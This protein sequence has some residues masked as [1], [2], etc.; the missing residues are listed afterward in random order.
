[1]KPSTSWPVGVSGFTDSSACSVSEAAA[2][3][4]A[5]SSED[6][7]SDAL[8]VTPCCPPQAV[9]DRAIAP[10]SRPDNNLFFF[11]NPP[12]VRSFTNRF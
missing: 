5:A 1:M 4:C 10:A 2:C 8:F 11:I 7:A 12:L 3:V 9:R 6:G